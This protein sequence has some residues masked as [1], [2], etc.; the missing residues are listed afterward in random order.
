MVVG[1]WGSV[2]RERTNFCLQAAGQPLP[3][4]FSLFYR[5]GKARVQIT[6]A[7][8]KLRRVITSA[9]ILKALVRKISERLREISSKRF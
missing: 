7:V 9:V 2:W 5:V 3:V 4:G 6:P 1:S 8:S